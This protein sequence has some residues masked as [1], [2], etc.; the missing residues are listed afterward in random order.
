MVDCCHW[1]VNWASA[2]QVLPQNSSVF[3][4]F[5]PGGV[6][7]I[8]DGAGAVLAVTGAVG[9][10]SRL[11]FGGGLAATDGLVGGGEAGFGLDLATVHLL[12]DVHK[13]LSGRG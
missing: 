2:K 11:V 5:F 1:S 9:G 8:M 12:P 7:I 3:V 4:R 10:G 13:F 6:S